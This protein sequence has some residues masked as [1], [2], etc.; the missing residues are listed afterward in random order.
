MP[1]LHVF[2]F[3]K[4]DKINNYH[5]EWSQNAIRMVREYVTGRFRSGQRVQD[6]GAEYVIVETTYQRGELAGAVV[7]VYPI[8]D[9]NMTVTFWISMGRVTPFITDHSITINN[10][11]L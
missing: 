7:K 6:S 4:N 3:K 8:T 2:I 5:G 1:K 9:R 11:E 10:A